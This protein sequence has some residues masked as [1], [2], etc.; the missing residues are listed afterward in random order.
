MGVFWHREIFSVSFEENFGA[1]PMIIK[2]F[3]PVC[4]VEKLKSGCN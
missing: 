2:Y 1:E 3:L 4:G